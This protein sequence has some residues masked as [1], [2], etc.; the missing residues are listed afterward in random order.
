MSPEIISRTRRLF[1][2]CEVQLQPDKIIIEA[3]E[4]ESC[5][6][7]LSGSWVILEFSCPAMMCDVSECLP[8]HQMTSGFVPPHTI[9][10]KK[11]KYL[12]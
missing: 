11:E 5:H 10:I 4:D 12:L 7:A 3:G 6:L 1:P 8:E 2:A 9:A